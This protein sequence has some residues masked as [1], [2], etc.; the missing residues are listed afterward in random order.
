MTKILKGLGIFFLIL[1]VFGMIFGK[2]DGSTQASNESANGNSKSAKYVLNEKEQKLLNAFLQEDVDI[3]LKGGDSLLSR[4]LIVTTSFEAAKAYD[5]NQ[6]GADQKYY[7][8]EVL[9]S[10]KITGINSGIGNEPYITLNGTNQFLSPQIHFDNPNIDKLANLTK[11]KKIRFVCIGN[12]AIVGTPIF[13][14]CQLAEDYIATKVEEIKP[15]LQNFLNGEKPNNDLASKLILL[16][17]TASRLLPDNS[18]CYSGGK[19][20]MKDID[21]VTNKNKKEWLKE[22]LKKTNAEMQQLGLKVP[23]SI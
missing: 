6:V 12:G 1:I 9:V 18:E 4:G 3:F 5:E 21:K 11:G 10:G 22:E 8:K 19:N 7:K 14:D 17:I 2:K 23:D 20:C 16:S 15:Q 13:K